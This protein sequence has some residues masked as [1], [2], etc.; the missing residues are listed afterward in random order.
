MFVRTTILECAM[1]RFFNFGPP[2]TLF[3]VLTVTGFYIDRVPYFTYFTKTH[4]SLI[5]QTWKFL[6]FLDTLSPFWAQFLP[7]S[8]V[9]L[10]IFSLPYC[11]IFIWVFSWP[12][13]R[14]C[15]IFQSFTCFTL[16]LSKRD[17]IPQGFEPSNSHPWL[18]PRTDVGWKQ[19][20]FSAIFSCFF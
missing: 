8:T 14:C 16:P 13:T 19:W 10:L 20:Y 9:W 11:F 18:N 4:F 3:H 17:G 5:L 7:L 6:L 2:Q 15:F 12:P 1:L